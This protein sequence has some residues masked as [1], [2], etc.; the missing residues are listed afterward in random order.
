[1]PSSDVLGWSCS[2]GAACHAEACEG[3]SVVNNTGTQS[4]LNVPR[5]VAAT[6]IE[7]STH[8]YVFSRILICT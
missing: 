6:F 8:D 1:M 5:D 4:N 3:G 7:S 2:H